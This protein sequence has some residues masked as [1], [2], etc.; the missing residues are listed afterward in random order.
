MYQSKWETCSTAKNRRVD[1]TCRW[2]VKIPLK[3]PPLQFRFRVSV[4]IS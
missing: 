3:P 1:G 4:I 2:K